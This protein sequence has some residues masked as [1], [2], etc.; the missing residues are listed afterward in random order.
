MSLLYDASLIITP[1]AYKENKLFA[2]KPQSGNGDL[3]WTRNGGGTRTNSQGL[4]EN[5]LANVPRLD[6]SQGSCPSIL[7]EPQRTNLV[8]DSETYSSTW[9]SNFT[10]ITKN[11]LSPSGIDNAST[12]INNVGAN[13]S[14]FKLIPVVSGN[15]YKFTFYIKKISGSWASTNA[16]QLY[17]W[18]PA[19]ASPSY[20]NI[21]TIVTTNWVRY[22]HTFTAS[23]TG[24]AYC[25]LISNELH[26][27]GLWG[28]QLEAGEYPTSYIPTTSATV[29]RVADVAGKTGISDLIGQNEGTLFLEIQALYD[30]SKYSLFSIFGSSSN[31]IAIGYNNTLN[32]LYFEYRV[33]S[34]Y[35]INSNIPGSVVKTNNNK[36]IVKYK[37]GEQSVFINGVKTNL[38]TFTNAFT[39]T[40]NNF[41]FS[42]DSSN[43]LPYYGKCKG[44]QLYKTALTDTQ[45]IQLTTL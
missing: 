44:V 34:Q 11:L 6:Y 16:L 10:S 31:K 3:T 35:L 9:G 40:L 14:I 37:S 5:V 42:Y 4:I 32:T 24:N 45:C 2:L 36:I 15:T 29:T 41:N 22:T 26:T 1:N 30:D 19:V 23:S 8:T 17:A 18:G 27:F 33:N 20:T 39:E 12:M 43:S 21:G 25:Q 38:G 7:L 13:T 28:A